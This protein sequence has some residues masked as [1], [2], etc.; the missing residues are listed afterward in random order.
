MQIHARR[1][2]EF[3]ETC[4]RYGFQEMLTEDDYET[5]RRKHLSDVPYR[6]YTDMPGTGP[7]PADLDDDGDVDAADLAELL[8]AWGA[9]P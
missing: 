8:L 9:C 5:I 7:C 3:A 2:T 6:P 4:R 1:C